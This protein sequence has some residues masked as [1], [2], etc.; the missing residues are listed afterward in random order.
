L[1]IDNGTVLN[2]TDLARKLN[3]SKAWVT[4]VYRIANNIED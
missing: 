1:I 4:K 3:A 2:Q